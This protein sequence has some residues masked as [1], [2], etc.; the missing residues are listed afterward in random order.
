M[1]EHRWKR[2]FDSTLQQTSSSTRF[3]LS[4]PKTYAV[5]RKIS[6][7][8]K[9]SFH[10][11]YYWSKNGT[12]LQGSASECNS[13]WLKM[14]KNIRVI[15]NVAVAAR[16]EIQYAFRILWKS[17]FIANALLVKEEKIEERW[18]FSAIPEVV[19]LLKTLDISFI[20][21]HKHSSALS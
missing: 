11:P 9:L 17:I 5:G 18:R 21:E 20:A 14:C 1:R 19:H 13:F 8:L 6:Q 2:S 4:S 16:A 12:R 15:R 3:Q 10:V 7:N